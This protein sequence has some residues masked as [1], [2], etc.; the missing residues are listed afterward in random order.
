MTA[1]T[2]F[3]VGVGPGDPDL[4]TLKAAR[5]IA[6]ADIV[7]YPLT[8]SGDALARGIAGAHLRDGQTEIG[9][10]LPMRTER[11]PAQDVYD[12]VCS[13][14]ATAL[15]AGQTVVLLCEGDPFF[16][17]SAM[18]IHDRLSTQFPTEVVP[19]VTSLTAAAARLG[20]PLAARDDVLKV[21]PGTLDRSILAQELATCDAAAIIKVGRHFDK[22]RD[23]I[24][25]ARLTGAASVVER[26]TRDDERIRSLGE[27]GD[28]E[29]PYFSTILIYRG[30]EA[31][32]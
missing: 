6:A 21:L 29:M 14:L 5:I 9:F 12:D 17:G 15:E 31:W 30:G 18:Y 1:G 10:T 4:I 27:I 24:G 7:A 16:Y 8:E 19:G 26:A 25:E 28:D 11:A 22:V 32:S 3:V 23:V 2:L 20:R 13:R